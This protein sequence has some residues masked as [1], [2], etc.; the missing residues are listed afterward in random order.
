VTARPL[1]YAALIVRFGLPDLGLAHA[2]YL[3][4][5]GVM[6]KEQGA[7]GAERVHYPRAYDPGDRTIDH[8]VFALKYDGVDLRVLRAV[9][10]AMPEGELVEAVIAQ[11]T[12]Q[13]VR[14]LW[15]LY[16]WLL[17]RSLRAP[18]LTQGNYVPLLDPANYVVGSSYR[19]RRPRIAVNALGP[20]ALCPVVR[21][22][23]RLAE[24]IAEAPALE[25]RATAF[26]ETVPPAILWR[27]TAYLYDKETRSSYAIER[28]TPREGRVE[29]FVGVLRDAWKG[30]S[31]SREVLVEVQNAIVEA[32][33]AEH[34]ERTEQNWV[35]RI[36]PRFEEEVF[37]VAPTPEALPGLLDAWIELANH[38][39]RRDDNPVD[40]VVGAAVVSFLFVYLHPFNDGNG[41]IH[42]WLLHW[43]LARRGFGPRDVV[44]PVSAAILH[45]A[46]RYDAVLESLSRPMRAHV[47]TE[48][49]GHRL[50]VLDDHADL[51]RHLDFTAHAEVLHDWLARAVDREMREEVEFL[52][53]F[54][55]AVEGLR[56]VREMPDRQERLFVQFVVQNRGRLS[57]RK[58]AQFAE[59]S[60]DE[61]AAMELAVCEAFELDG[62]GRG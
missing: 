58:R 17:G 19:S 62:E 42:R 36:G 50:V 46:G 47:R 27:A 8:L 10:A 55:R 53:R 54:D 7:D 2:S 41:R 11:P 14:R 39:T 23:P 48:F 61:L 6:V 33:Y 43:A 25:G 9:L 52:A 29:R 12:G 15:F 4:P 49:Q 32:A 37:L 16:E 28:E 22:T 60:D 21:R 1:G 35:G 3:R 51:F 5:A 40:P 38:L 24:Q 44:L 45:D 34:C 30:R 18:D 57:Q 13:Y 20:A 59:V 26:I 31:L 56:A